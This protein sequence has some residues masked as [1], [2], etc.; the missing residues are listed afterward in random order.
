M[1]RQNGVPT[2][3][4]QVSLDATTDQVLQQ[5]VP[6]G[7]HGKNKSE[8]AS[9]IVRQWIWHNQEDLARVGVQIVPGSQSGNTK[10]PRPRD[11]KTR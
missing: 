6:I 5:L 10:R 3:R 2:V 1:S 7:I 9:W 11:S 4:L 8:V